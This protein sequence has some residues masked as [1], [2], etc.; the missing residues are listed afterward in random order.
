VGAQRSDQRGSWAAEAVAPLQTLDAAAAAAAVML[1]PAVAAAQ[2]QDAPAVAA[3]LPCVLPH[4]GRRQAAA[5]LDA[6]L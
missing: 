3:V 1:Q 5:S 4:A 6:D 2:T